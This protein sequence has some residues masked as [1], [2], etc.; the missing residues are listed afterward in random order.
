MMSDFLR[1]MVLGYQRM[2]SP[3]LPPACR[4]HPSCSQYAV[5]SLRIHGSWKGS[6]LTALRIARCN[7]FFPGG[8]DPVPQ[9]DSR[10]E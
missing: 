7:P 9:G 5:E 8:M 6:V 2:I 4:F 1:W 10:G 3:V